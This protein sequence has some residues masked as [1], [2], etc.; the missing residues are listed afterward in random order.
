MPF[1]FWAIL[2]TIAA[3]QGLFLAVML[4]LKKENRLPNR[5][6]AAFL[7]LLAF[8]LFEWVLWWTGGMKKWPGFIG[9][10]F[11]VPLLYGPL[12]FLF[13]QSTFERKSLMARDLWHFLPAVIGLFF[14]LPIYLRF[15]ENASASLA[16]IPRLRDYPWFPVL[17]FVQMIGYGVWVGLRFRPFFLEKKEL[18]KWHRWLLAA[19]WGIV[20]AYLLYRLLGVLGFTAVGWRYFIAFSQAFFIYLV[21]WLGYIKPR[22]FS[23]IPLEVAANPAKYRKSSLTPEQ[24]RRI[25]QRIA[26]LMDG[27]FYRQEDFSLDLLARR[28]GEQRHHVSQAINEQS[29][30]SFSEYVNDFRIREALRLLAKKS[31]AEMNISEVAFGV[32]FNTKKAFNLAFKRHTGMTPSEYRANT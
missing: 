10:G 11:S 24:S 27:G 5:L 14:M 22:V 8:T 17:I 26:E 2:A 31:K 13:Y 28:V 29:G 3:G 19:Y 25:F 23:G 6:L 1:T 4:F 21:A 18:R 30:G 9:A 20:A 32:G 12:M 15:F 7:F 16:W